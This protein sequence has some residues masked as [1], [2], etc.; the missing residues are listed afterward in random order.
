V[1]RRRITP[2][3]IEQAIGLLV[4]VTTAVEMSPDEQHSFSMVIDLLNR[5]YDVGG[6]R[7]GPDGK[8]EVGL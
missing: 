8:E 3:Q 4:D 1:R 7:V 6:V 5:Y 2:I